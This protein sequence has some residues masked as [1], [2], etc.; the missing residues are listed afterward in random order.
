MAD[1]GKVYLDANNLYLDSF[2]LARKIWDD[3]FRPTV[4]ARAADCVLLCFLLCAALTVWGACW[5]LDLEVPDW[6]VAWWHAYRHL[7]RGVLP[8]AGAQTALARVVPSCST[9]SPANVRQGHR[10]Q[11]SAIKT[12][13]YTGIGSGNAERTVQVGRCLPWCS[14]QHAWSLCSDPLSVDGTGDGAGPAD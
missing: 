4:R 6:A 3:G 12:E 13:S 5:R 9:G 10:A 8:R 11:H 2:K 14:S 7:R 1:D